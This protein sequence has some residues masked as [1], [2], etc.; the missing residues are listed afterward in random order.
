MFSCRSVCAPRDPAA[1]TVRI[2]M[3][4]TAEQA[5]AERVAAEEREAQLRAQEVEEARF[6]AV[7][8]ER[9]AEEARLRLQVE[10][11]KEEARR[12]AEEE[13]LRKE[14][15]ARREEQS[16]QE[17]EEAERL[18]AARRAEVE[19]LAQARKEAVAAFLKENKF[20][21]LTAP[22]KTMFKTT[23]PIHCAAK[24]GDEQ[25]VK[26]LLEE[27]V[28]SRQKNSAG[29]TAVQVAQKNNKEGSHA[30]VLRCLGGA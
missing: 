19:R 26:M 24:Q 10:K 6:R 7:E 23:Y 3:P 20:K 9:Q 2:D 15:Y 25:M 18:E 4:T 16:R 21:D 11:E 22:K 29:K 30:G 17:R 14:A 27:G 1:D 13:R 8:E 5:E 28:D 12:I